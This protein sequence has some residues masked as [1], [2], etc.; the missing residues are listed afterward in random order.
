[1]CPSNLY[2]TSTLVLS[3]IAV[4]EIFVVCVTLLHAVSGSPLI[5]RRTICRSLATRLPKLPNRLPPLD[6]RLPESPTRLQLL[7]TRLP[8]LGPVLVLNTSA[9]TA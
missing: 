2:L 8:P 7:A 1:M 6:T 3:C 5:K 4:D 9:S